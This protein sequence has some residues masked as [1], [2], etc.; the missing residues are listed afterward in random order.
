VRTIVDCVSSPDVL[1][2][3]AAE[4][5]AFE[6]CG[7]DGKLGASDNMPFGICQSTGVQSTGVEFCSLE[8]MRVFRWAVSTVRSL[9][10]IQERM[11]WECGLGMSVSRLAF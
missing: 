7:H 8:S 2:S 11:C 10:A 4:V 1:L 9:S 3:W 5:G 6:L